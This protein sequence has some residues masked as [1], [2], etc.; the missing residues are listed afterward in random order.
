MHGPSSDDLF[1]FIEASL[2]RTINVDYN[3]FCYTSKINKYYTREMQDVV[4]GTRANIN[5]FDIVEALMEERRC[6]ELMHKDSNHTFNTEREQYQAIIRKLLMVKEQVEK[7]HQLASLKNEIIQKDSQIED[8]EKDKRLLKAKI[9]YME[10]QITG[11]KDNLQN[12]IR[13]DRV[14]ED[15]FDK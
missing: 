6:L 3:R 12:M 2:E 7:K 1:R 9:K 4:D 5:I 10:E 11:H 14:K 8:L 13:D 15:K